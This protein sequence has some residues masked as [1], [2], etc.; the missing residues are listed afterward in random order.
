MILALTVFIK[1]NT[2]TWDGKILQQVAQKKNLFIKMII[3][4][5][6]IYYVD[7]SGD[8]IVMA[9]AENA[10]GKSLWNFEM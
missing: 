1:E 10:S 9:E 7:N 4:I 2:T 3:N 8:Y 5:V 6:G